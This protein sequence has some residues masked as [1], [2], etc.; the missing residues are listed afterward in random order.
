MSRMFTQAVRM[1][2]GIGSRFTFLLSGC[3]MGMSGG[4]LEK[5]SVEKISG[6]ERVERMRA[7]ESAGAGEEKLNGRE[8]ENCW[9]DEGEQ[10]AADL[11]GCG[12]SASS[13][14]HRG[15]PLTWTSTSTT[16]A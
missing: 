9:T 11:L 2:A 15:A 6:P 4:R 7:E 10:I 5:G 3:E 14:T 12:T 13:P 16:C 1:L 8:E